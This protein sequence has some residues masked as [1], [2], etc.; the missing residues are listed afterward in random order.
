MKTKKNAVIIALALC[1]LCSVSNAQESSKDKSKTQLD[2][3]S[4][5]ENTDA[6]GNN[7][8][9][10]M[11]NLTTKE[12]PFKDSTNFDNH[13][14]AR[15]MNAYEIGKLKL[16]SKIPDAE[17]FTLNYKLKLSDNFYTFAIS[18]TKG[19]Y[20]L[21]TDLITFDKDYNI[22]DKLNIA[23]DEIGESWFSKRSMILKDS[24]ILEKNYS[25]EDSEGDTLEIKTTYKIGAD[26][27][28]T[29]ISTKIEPKEKPNNICECAEK[30]C[31]DAT[32][33][34]IARICQRPGISVEEI[35]KFISQGADI[36]SAFRVRYENEDEGYSDDGVW[37]GPIF[38]FIEK[39]AKLD[40]TDEDGNIILMR[41]LQSDDNLKLIKLLLD[42]KAAVNV[43]NYSGKTP[44]SIA[45]ESDNID[46][47]KL[48]L[49]NKANPNK[50]IIEYEKG[51]FSLLEY[52]AFRGNVELVEL[53]IKHGAKVKDTYAHL[54]AADKASNVKK[55][56]N[57]WAIV[58]L[59]LA[60]G[61]DINAIA[62][63][64]PYKCDTLLSNAIVQHNLDMVKYLIEHG[65]NLNLEGSAFT[66][67]DLA[68][69]S[70]FNPTPDL[71]KNAEAIK[72]YIYSLTETMDE[73]KAS[74]YLPIIHYAVN[75]RD[76]EKVQ[77]ILKDVPSQA[78]AVDKNDNTPLHFFFYGFSCADCGGGD[79]WGISDSLFK[80]QRIQTEDN[81][82][83]IL[84]LL[85]KN[86]ANVK[87]VNK[88]GTTPIHAA[89]K[90][91]APEE[92][93]S[94]LL[95]HSE[96]INARDKFGKTPL[97][98]VES[99]KM[100]EFFIKNGAD[101]NVVSSVLKRTPLHEAAI[102][103]Y[104]SEEITKVLVKAGADIKAKDKYGKTAFDLA[105][106][107]DNSPTAL[108]LK[109]LEG[110]S[111]NEPIS[112]SFPIALAA[113]NKDWETVKLLLEKG[114]KIDGATSYNSTALYF[115][116]R[117]SNIEMV[118]YLT[119]RGA[120]VNTV[121]KGGDTPLSRAV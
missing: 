58:I 14:N 57:Y 82:K 29:E 101:V 98:Y 47:V 61:A 5:S 16:K 36:N 9:S 79:D 59:L 90:N 63:D 113:E 72:E 62:R 48:L 83:P 95:K 10:F 84:E 33:N 7:E 115:A 67:P 37:Y 121:N 51:K 81:V 71:A 96:D 99:A 45:V 88:N 49:E 76:L 19:E 2:I 4:T 60:K 15:Q 78:K 70:T 23:Y 46:Y 18:Y 65:A 73:D 120:D 66:I 12:P 52:A 41:Q 64:A 34:F 91:N 103:R 35:D 22:I 104:Q 24:I 44:L 106:E 107:N 114:A 111:P 87:A 55:V 68:D 74:G 32:K 6:K 112:G 13:T 54:L 50:G 116:V 86:G 77:Q 109:N 56:D 94:V 92:F 25:A 40:V 1:L 53:L 110:A 108:Y 89:V 85:L 38:Y 42:K 26:G 28:F 20:E 117:N 43:S 31:S 21:F 17:N 39:G 105:T 8:Q 80:I 75:K 30:K 102:K 27:K 100:A 69:R 93:I 11:E 3:G 97:H 118:R 119:E